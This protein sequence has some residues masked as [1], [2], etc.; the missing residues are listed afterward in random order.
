MVMFVVACKCK[1]EERREQSTTTNK[2]AH[3]SHNISNN[4]NKSHKQISSTPVQTWHQIH[5]QYWLKNKYTRIMEKRNKFIRHSICHFK[6]CHPVIEKPEFRAHWG[7]LLLLLFF[8]CVWNWNRHWWPV[9][10]IKYWACITIVTSIEQLFKW[11]L[12]C[13]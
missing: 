8:V 4:L 13:N 3:E 9:I 5:T 6:R 1:S 7:F 10:T 2:S 12:S 11:M